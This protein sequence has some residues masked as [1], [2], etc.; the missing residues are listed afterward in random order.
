M[1]D[2][3]VARVCNYRGWADRQ[4]ASLGA[5]RLAG[6]AP[7]AEGR[8]TEEEEEEEEGF[9]SRQTKRRWPEGPGLAGSVLWIRL[10]SGGEA[11]G[12]CLVSQNFYLVSGE[13]KDRGDEGCPWSLHPMPGRQ[14][15]LRVRG[16]QL[17]PG[18]GEPLL[19]QEG[20]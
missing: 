20:G 12:P 13:R 11:L 6:C 17:L 1:G 16:E 15:R 19:V 18:E 2:G 9:P 3:A 4:L 5:D 14:D 10:G 8:G 7:W